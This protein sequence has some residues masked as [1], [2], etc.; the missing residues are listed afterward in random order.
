MVFEIWI[1]AQL[2]S[3]KLGIHEW[4]LWRDPVFH[5]VL[6]ASLLSETDSFHNKRPPGTIVLEDGFPAW[7]QGLPAS[8]RRNAKLKLLH[9]VPAGVQIQDLAIL[10]KAL[11]SPA[12]Y[13][14]SGRHGGCNFPQ[15][16]R[17]EAAHKAEI[18]A[19]GSV[20]LMHNQRTKYH[21]M[22]PLLQWNSGLPATEIKINKD[23]LNPHKCG[24]EAAGS[25][26]TALIIGIKKN[27]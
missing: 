23:Q 11:V 1:R 16:Q 9:L 10:P 21:L 24:K 14:H 17:Q 5:F 26:K 2:S 13:T 3:I 22:D 4:E 15:A 20:C 8:D 6:L 25:Q 12:T 7:L 18:R 27:K 19:T